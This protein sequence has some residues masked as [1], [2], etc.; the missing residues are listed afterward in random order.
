MKKIDINLYEYIRKNS[1]NMSHNDLY[2]LLLDWADQH[3]E[4][5]NELAGY[6]T[7]YRVRYVNPNGEF[8]DYTFKGSE[9]ENPHKEARMCYNDAIKEGAEIGELWYCPNP[10]EIG[11]NRYGRLLAS[12]EK[13]N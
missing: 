3:R 6:Y 11:Q 5:Q 10:Y 13:K 12:F 9:F 1:K 8:Y 2:Y 7:A 4:I